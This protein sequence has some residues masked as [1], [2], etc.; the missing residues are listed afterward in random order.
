MKYMATFIQAHAKA[1]S[2][3]ALL[4]WGHHINT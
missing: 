3:A 2:E 1:V 4:G